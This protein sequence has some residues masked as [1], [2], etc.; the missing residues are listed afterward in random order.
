LHCLQF[1]RLSDG[2]R[3][4][5]DRTLFKVFAFGHSSHSQHAPP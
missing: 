2:E 1:K 3:L 5:A 4:A